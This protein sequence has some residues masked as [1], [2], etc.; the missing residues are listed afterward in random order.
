MQDII[1]LQNILQEIETLFIKCK[2]NLQYCVFSPFLDAHILL[3]SIDKRILLT[4]FYSK[5]AAQSTVNHLTL[6]VLFLNMP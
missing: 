3:T 2:N 5:G 1:A 4:V 6:A